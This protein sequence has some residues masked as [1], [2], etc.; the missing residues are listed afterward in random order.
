MKAFKSILILGIIAVF[1]SACADAP[2][3]QKGA[4]IGGAAGAG[5]GA[6]IGH[7]SDHKGEGALIGGAAGAVIGGLIGAQLDKQQAELGEIAEVERPS[8]GE[9][10]VTLREKVL[11][12][13]NEYS[14]KPGAEANL[15]RVADVLVKYPDFNINVE[16]HTDNTGHETYN[17]W[18]SEKRAETVADFIVAEGAHPDRIMVIGYGETQPVTTNDTAEG[19]QQN[20]RV[21]L[22]IVPRET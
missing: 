17:Q 19:R 15:S 14:L 7:Q 12:D 10:I 4:V 13:V 6:V 22:H 3:W 21:E 20:R 1:A 9:L 8:E 18:L 2:K 11:F 16:G 5:A